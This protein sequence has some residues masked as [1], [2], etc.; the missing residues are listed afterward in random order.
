MFYANEFAVRKLLEAGADPRIKVALMFSAF[1]S[2]WKVT[3]M[4]WDA[5]PGNI[6]TKSPAVMAREGMFFPISDFVSVNPEEHAEWVTRR[7]QVMD[8]LAP[9]V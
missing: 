2:V 7:L 4:E 3:R 9:F 5:L 6:A 8:T 1:R